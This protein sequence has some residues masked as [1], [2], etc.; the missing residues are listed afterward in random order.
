VRNV[1]SFIICIDV[2]I[3]KDASTNKIKQWMGLRDVSGVVTNYIKLDTQ[4]VLGD[5]RIQ[6]SAHVSKHIIVELL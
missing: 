3:S 5:W 1:N 2:N 4:P 6:V